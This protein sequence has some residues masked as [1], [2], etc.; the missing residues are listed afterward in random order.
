MLA[1][2]VCW[3]CW[4]F[5]A[6]RYKQMLA[7]LVFIG[8]KSTRMCA[9][10]YKLA[11]DGWLTVS[12]LELQH[13]GICPFCTVPTLFFFLFCFCH[14]SPRSVSYSCWLT[15]PLRSVDIRLV[16]P[17]WTSRQNI[18]SVWGHPATQISGPMY[19]LRALGS[20][21]QESSLAAESA[22]LCVSPW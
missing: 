8:N 5:T 20:S 10:W 17:L 12:E 2:L 11:G 14:S 7:C 3:C 6:D 1:G 13:V 16:A 9:K 19:R 22:G 4:K 18:P 21:Q 15:A